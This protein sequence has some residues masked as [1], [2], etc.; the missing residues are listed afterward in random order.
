MKYSRIIRR[1]ILIAFVAILVLAAAAYVF[2]HTTLFA[3]Y[4]RGKAVQMAEAKLGAG[5]SIKSISIPWDQLAA[6]VRGITIQGRQ[7][8]AP[9]LFTARR[10]RIGVE[11]SPLLSGHIKL[12]Q[13][14]V[15]QPVVRV[16]INS[17]GQTN[18]P[19]PSAVQTAASSSSSTTINSLFSLAIHHLE[20]NQGTIYYNDEKIPLSAH[21]SGFRAH[22]S[23]NPRS[24]E[25]YGSLGYT[26]GQIVANN[27]R[28]LENSANL[29]FTAGRSGL[30]CDPLRI[31]LPRSRLTLYASVRNYS[32]P[33]IDGK[34]LAELSTA[35]MAN[36]LR[37]PTLPAGSISADG[38]LT[39]EHVAGRPFLESLRLLGNLNSSH[40]EMQRGKAT[41][42]LDAV[43]ARFSL[44]DGNVRIADARG[45]VLGGEIRIPSAEI[46][47]SGDS[48][49]RL[50]AVLTN[51]SLRKLS[52]AVPSK[53]SVQLAVV[54]RAD[55]T[56][57]L[58]WMN[59]F[60]GLRINSRANIVAP[61]E[62]ELS[63]GEIPLNGSIQMAY[64]AALDRASFGNSEL[65]IG[66]TAL[67][68]N[69]VLSNRSDL[70]L[71]L[72]AGDLSQFSTLAAKVEEV[73]SSNTSRSFR[74]PRMSG[75]AQFLGR[76]TGSPRDPHLAGQLTARD[77]QLDSTRWKTIHATLAVSPSRAAI[78]DGV[79]VSQSQRRID[80]AA[81]AALS[82]WSVKPSSRISAH[83]A[84]AD[85][86]ISQLQTLAR[87][88]YPVS[89]TL[90]LDASA[91][92][93][94]QNLTG[95]GWVRVANATAWNQPIKI[96]TVNFHGDS[97]A[98]HAD[99]SAE[100]PAGSIAA[101]AIYKV[102]SK[103]YQLEVSSSGLKLGELAIVEARHLPL[104]G[105]LVVKGTGSASL[106]NPQFAATIA[107]R[108]LAFRG[109]HVSDFRSQ[110]DLADRQ[111]NLSASAGIYQGTLQAHGNVALTGDYQTTATLDAR[112]ISVGAM[113]A[114]YLKNGG[115]AP[116]ERANLHLQVQ[117]PLK[118]PS[119][120]FIRAELP[121]MSLSY[122]TV[123][124]SLVRPLI[125]EYHAGQI[126]VQPT[127]IKGTDIDLRFQ[128][129][130]P[131]ARSK[132]L[133][134]SA[135]GSM[136]LGLL[137][138][139]SN[140]LQSSG[141]L[142]INLAAQGTLAQPNM[143]GNLR[144]QNAT[145]ASASMPVDLTSVNGDIN[146][147]GRRIQ[148]AHLSG[149]VNG[150]SMAAQGSVDLG[151]APDFDLAVAAQSVSVNYPAGVEARVNGNL[152]LNGPASDSALTG[153]VVIDYLGLTQ[154]MDIASLASQFSS[155]GASG[156]PSNFEKNAK[157]NVA[158]QSSSTLN[159]SSSQLSLQGAANLDVT[160]TLA[161]PVILGRTTLTSGE[162]FFMG[163]RY[164]VKSGTIEFANPTRTS[165]IVDLYATTTV[166]QYDIS[167]HFLGPVDEIKT[168]FTST[169]ALPQADIINLLAF[170]QTTEQA[171]TSSPTPG[172]LGAE[173]VIAKGVA[174]QL[175]GKVQKLA[176]ISQLSIS[177]VIANAQQNPGAEVSIQQRVSGRLLVT[178]TTNTAQ[179]QSTAVQVQY[180]LGGGLSVSVLRDQ[181]GGY[182]V[183][184]HLHKSF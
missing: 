128:G 65:R 94:R 102:Q 3:N 130:I 154:Q 138:T 117:G 87:V 134:V 103:Q 64:D 15:N 160:G 8:G 166:N 101:S 36:V 92:G 77:L 163:K 120:M 110:L 133:R 100:S 23:F 43:R 141:K 20:I 81:S 62:R 136:D 86:Q 105:T 13:L 168:S 99:L 61:P 39:Y 34:Y 131:L 42:S 124:L 71:K 183:D 161:D 157:L 123:Q 33:Q 149:N 174:S 108:Q 179:T 173:S 107:S 98:L 122:R 146:V 83:V 143:Q 114:Q 50:T 12:S 73:A 96:V 177:P 21:L 47:L 76:V 171:A 152:R 7:N 140:G 25:Y 155:G 41:V 38:T 22:V 132:P 58:S 78:S 28:P 9:P 45:D 29:N 49:S 2:V 90:S 74:M 57:Q 181:N 35:E 85:F 67:S 72:S 55:V 116:K 139:V 142:E 109:E 127:E 104:S 129:T 158:V 165:P 145:F 60:H 182:G 46:S 59:H 52:E 6:D 66:Q 40:L 175:S 169:P 144:L 95:H 24:T 126:A 26:D 56:A 88:N 113:A 112:S 159:L 48:A 70:T 11:I 10:L 119:Q 180:R 84:A 170:G 27:Y 111:L 172:A 93:T 69:G 156:P 148:I 54:G 75:S 184:V 82:H 135:N 18:L 176:G 125:A 91:S 19:A 137:Q 14:I 115:P 121:A 151:N 167:L 53:T 89:G 63:A 37:D 68:V 31:T 5:V 162:L 118:E 17:Q 80:V 164:E 178:F 16:R 30:T 79:L 1:T 51:L 44:A 106:D 153:R 32:D 97:G 147:S 150:G 4:A